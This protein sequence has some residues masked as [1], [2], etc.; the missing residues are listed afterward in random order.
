[1]R[2]NEIIIDG[3]TKS[4]GGRMVLDHI[5]AELPAGILCLSGKSGCGKTTLARIIAGLDKP[6]SG[7]VS[8]MTG[9]VT[10]MFQEPRLFP[11]FSALENV[12]CVSRQKEAERRAKELLFLLSLNSEDMMKKPRE[13]SGGMS[14]RV[15]LAR[16][17][18]YAVS[19]GGNTV[20]LDE[21]F[22]GLDPT[23]K[24]KAAVLVTGEL[25]GKNILVITHDSS[26]AELLG[27][28]SVSF[29]E[30]CGGCLW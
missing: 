21:P 11:A 6:D 26:D 16:A 15:S 30:P 18:L 29:E 25:S 4:F 19:C 23:A 3:I 9:Y 22:K 20:I 27:G 10:Y 2:M 24:E 12:A 13:L 7:T 5:R 1:M 28:S 8:G 17:V 14:Q